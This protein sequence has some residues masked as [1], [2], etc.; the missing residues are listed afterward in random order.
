MSGFGDY[1]PDADAYDPTAPPDPEQVAR[2]IAELDYINWEISLT[3]AAR[4]RRIGV[5]LDLLAWLKRSGHLR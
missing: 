1:D 2:K 4:R 5:A 3:D